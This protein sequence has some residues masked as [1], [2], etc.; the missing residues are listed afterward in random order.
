MT[1]KEAAEYEC[2]KVRL[3]R[4]YGLRGL[5]RVTRDKGSMVLLW[6]LSMVLRLGGAEPE[7]EQIG[8]GDRISLDWEDQGLNLCCCDCGLV[9]YVT[10]EVTENILVMKFLRNEEETERSRE[11]KRVLMEEVHV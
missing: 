7:Y 11:R 4:S 5:S 3:K 8:D 9:H 1:K 2:S 10:F 6:M